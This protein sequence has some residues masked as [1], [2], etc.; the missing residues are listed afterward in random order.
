MHKYF[1]GSAVNLI[2]TD[3]YNKTLLALKG[4]EMTILILR[5]EKYKETGTG[6]KKFLLYA[7]ES[8]MGFEGNSHDHTVK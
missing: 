8:M 3:I 7:D 6:K 1:H 2:G 5:M 4:N